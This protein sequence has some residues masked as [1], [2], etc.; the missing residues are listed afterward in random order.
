MNVPL[1]A[2]RLLTG[3]LVAGALVLAALVA[4]EPE[5]AGLD[6]PPTS[7][8]ALK[9]DARSQ[10]SDPA[11]REAIE[12]LFPTPGLLQQALRKCANILRQMNRGEIEA[13]VGMAF[14]FLGQTMEL[15]AAGRLRP[16]G[17]GDAV[18]HLFSLL[19][20][21][22]GVPSPFPSGAAIDAGEAALARLDADG[23]SIVVPSGGARIELAP[24]DL[25][26]E[27]W[28]AL[29]RVSGDCRTLLGVE[30]GGDCRPPFYRFTVYPASVLA[31]SPIGELCLDSPEGDGADLHIASRDA[32]G[33][34][35]FLPP[36][37]EPGTLAC[38]PGDGLAGI[39]GWGAL[40]RALAA[41]LSPFQPAPLIAQELPGGFRFSLS[42]SWVIK[43]GVVATAIA[44][45]VAIL[46]ADDDSEPRLVVD[47]PEGGGAD[48]VGR[49]FHVPW[50]SGT[51]LQRVELYL[52]SFAPGPYEF[53]LTAYEEE[54]G[55]REIGSS[56]VSVE[57]PV[58]DR[59]P[60]WGP[61]FPFP[62]VFSFDTGPLYVSRIPFRLSLPPGFYLPIYFA[63]SGCEVGDMACE[64]SCPIVET[65][66]TAPPLDTFRRRGI[67]ARLYG[68]EPY[69]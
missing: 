10:C 1:S 23:G 3:A 52:W 49:G 9:E 11:V 42:N 14:D 36:T 64:T 41:L 39:G 65:E 51:T 20:G 69:F 62:T 22:L 8:L 6:R 16:G 26:G 59:R 2:S 24:G 67:R 61:I 30:P 15:A 34:L 58:V 35:V 27:A 40:G 33:S 46:N 29:A 57:F 18:V 5:R 7:P 37:G 32:G 48:L 19:F 66:G 21:R 28:V 13:S 25:S 68:V 45:P 55:G 38:P 56:S 31:G 43:G 60:D 4:C 44:I 63:V 50:P 47:C 12:A 53:T 54:F 17:D